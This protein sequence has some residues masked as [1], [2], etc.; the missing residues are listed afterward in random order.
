MSTRGKL[1]HAAPSVLWTVVFVCPVYLFCVRHLSPGC[2]YGFAAAGALA[3]ALPSAALQRLALSSDLAAYRRLR[4]PLLLRLTQD[5]AWIRRV[6]RDLEPR[7]RRDRKIVA[8]IL[9]DTWMRERFHLGAFLF[10]SLCS[11]AAISHAQPLWFLSLILVNVLYNLY[12]IWLQQYLRLRLKP[13][14]R[15]RGE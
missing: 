12:P 5:A 1:F 9:R 13:L 3:M 11:L 10:T 15:F 14:C 8:G 7:I 4:V 6:S 2:V